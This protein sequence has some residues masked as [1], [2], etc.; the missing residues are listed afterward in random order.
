MSEATLREEPVPAAS[1]MCAREWMRVLSKYR[2]PTHWR[3]VWEIGV[4]AVPFVA[5]LTAAW[6]L[7]GIS[8]WLALI[9]TIPAAGFLVRLFLIQHDC[10]HGAFFRSKT[11]ND[12]VGRIIGVVTFTPYNVWRKCHAIHHGASGN[13]DQRGVGDIH[14]ATVREYQAMSR[15]RKIQY[16]V[17]RHPITLFAL[18]PAYLYFVQNRLPFGLMKYRTYWISAMG[19]N[20]AIAVVAGILIWFLGVWPFLTIYLPTVYFAAAIGMWLFYVQHQFEDTQ[21]DEEADWQVHHAAL[22][23]SSHYVLPG[24]LNWMTAN[25]GIHHVH[26]LYARIP[27]Y[28][29][30]QVLRDHPALDA[31]ENRMTLMESF[32]CVKLQLWDEANR[33]LVSYREA[34]AL[35]PAVA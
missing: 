35:A 15:W 34:R 33:K 1:D 3:S 6:F 24:W 13:L 7:Y 8:P 18:A 5:L 25:I 16:R 20:L 22:H 2:E 14:T 4:T 12:W 32:R 10:G 19:T 21:W 30:K 11:A 17:Y 9:F 31:E 23:G 26:H 29:L 27:F 28:R